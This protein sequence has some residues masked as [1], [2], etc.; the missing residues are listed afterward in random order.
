MTDT[1]NIKFT[2]PTGTE[3][4]LPVPLTHW[5]GF[6]NGLAITHYSCQAQV[7]I[8]LRYRKIDSAIPAE[9]IAQN[10]AANAKAER[11]Q[12]KAARVYTPPG[13]LTQRQQANIEFEKDFGWPVR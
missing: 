9:H 4:V 11:V 8:G 6:K 1:V 13:G 5:V 2:G 3:R 10:I 7:D 12:A